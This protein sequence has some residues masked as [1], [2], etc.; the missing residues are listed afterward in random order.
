MTSSADIN[1][2]SVP[3]VSRDK[4]QRLR[5]VRIIAFGLLGLVG[6]VS[7]ILFVI[8]LSSPISKIKAQQNQILSQ[9]TTQQDKAAKLNVVKER[10]TTISNIFSTRTDYIDSLKLILSKKPDDLK[11]ISLETNKESINMT[12]N[13]NSLL[14]IN[15]FLN[16]V[17]DTGKSD[18]KIKSVL[19]DSLAVNQSLGVYALSIK[20]KTK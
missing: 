20:I 10:V 1:L 17:I 5:S 7:V 16:T 4:Q 9:I 18:K 8:N 15:N 14:T 3:K 12:V 6:S 11:L 13:S 19:L 2:I